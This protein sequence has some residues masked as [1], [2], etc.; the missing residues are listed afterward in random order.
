L[1]YELLC[2]IGRTCAC[3][4]V[5]RLHPCI[6]DASGR[7]TAELIAAGRLP[8]FQR[9]DTDK[10]RGRVAQG[11]ISSFATAGLWPR[12]GYRGGRVSKTKS[13]T[14]AQGRPR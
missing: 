8:V 10:K 1:Q 4:H 13:N 2:H 9:N 12:S 7:D 5:A 3:T 14:L 11:R 6:Y